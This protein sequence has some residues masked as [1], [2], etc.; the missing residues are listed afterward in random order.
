MLAVP[1]DVLRGDHAARGIRGE[2]I[3]FWLRAVSVPTFGRHAQLTMRVLRQA[4]PGLSVTENFMLTWSGR[5]ITPGIRFCV[6]FGPVVF[7]QEP[8]CLAVCIIERRLK[9]LNLKT[10]TKRRLWVMVRSSWSHS[11][12]SSGSYAGA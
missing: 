6:D 9:F 10:A 7:S 5:V 11:A 1:V 8:A 2:E 4:V 3:A 12:C